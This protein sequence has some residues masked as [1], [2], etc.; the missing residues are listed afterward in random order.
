MSL[1]DELIAEFN[2]A[3][4]YAPMLQDHPDWTKEQCLVCAR[5]G[6]AKAITGLRKALQMQ[7]EGWGRWEVQVP[8]WNNK[9]AYCRNIPTVV[10]LDEARK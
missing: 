2:G 1:L 4:K 8:R 6:H 9:I 7:A 3:I 5:E 10:M